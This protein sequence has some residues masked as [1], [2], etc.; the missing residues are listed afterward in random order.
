MTPDPPPPAT[1][2]PPVGAD[3]AS[4]LTWPIS[5]LGSAV[6]VFL[7]GVIGLVPVLGPVTL[8]GWMMDGVGRLSYRRRELPWPRWGQL[9]LGL[10]ILAVELVYFSGCILPLLL[11][12]HAAPGSNERT[13]WIAASIAL[14]LVAVIGL[15]STLEAIGRDR[16][17]QLA[18]VMSKVIS[19]PEATLQS[20]A[21][22][23]ALALVIV[24][25][26]LLDLMWMW[27]LLGAPDAVID[28]LAKFHAIA[29]VY[30]AARLV[31][32]PYAAAVMAAVLYR[33]VIDAN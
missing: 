28:A 9:G 31:V 19:R 12:S 32:A 14:G 11:A 3:L 8:L 16:P 30:W 27:S 5:S 13:E 23:A 17:L 29:A 25:P 18:A 4:C 20:A 33:Y 15:P 1:S 6:K 10:R 26:L 22:I 24:V 21:V 7:T 2:S